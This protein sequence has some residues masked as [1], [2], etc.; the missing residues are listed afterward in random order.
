MKNIEKV[1][2]LEGLNIHYLLRDYL[3]DYL[4]FFLDAYGCT[5]IEEYGAFF[6]LTAQEDWNNYQQT[7]LQQPFDEALPE[8]TENITIKSDKAE[9]SFIHSCFI[10]GNDYGISVFYD[11]KLLIG[12]K[13]QKVLECAEKVEVNI[14]VRK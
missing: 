3:F 1:A 13:K 7:G 9:V 6:L 5:G 8:F 10:I 14:N 2:D 12:E 11:P 4:N